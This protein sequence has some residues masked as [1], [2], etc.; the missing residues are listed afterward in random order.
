MNKAHTDSLKDRGFIHFINLE[1]DLDHQDKSN[2]SITIA[3]FNIRLPTKITSKEK[4]DY[5]KSTYID[6]GRESI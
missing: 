4:R 6:I 1:V 2:K 3:Y 5:M